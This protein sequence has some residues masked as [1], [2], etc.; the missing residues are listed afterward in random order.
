MSV[1][2]LRV[3]GIPVKE[4]LFG[5]MPVKEVLFG[6][7][8]VKEVR[9]CGISVKEV[10]VCGMSVKELRTSEVADVNEEPREDVVVREVLELLLRALALRN[11]AVRASHPNYVTCIIPKCLTA[12]QN[13]FVGTIF[14]AVAILEGNCFFT[15]KHQ[16]GFKRACW[17]RYGHG[18]T[19]PR[20]PQR[21]DR[22][23]WIAHTNRDQPKRSY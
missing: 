5:G 3:C 17:T 15:L 14:A 18:G 23:R 12:S 11:V 6:G 13:P 4:V 19:T 9:V 16:I 1:N 22:A 2:E 8:P 7:I 10:R 21:S 20:C